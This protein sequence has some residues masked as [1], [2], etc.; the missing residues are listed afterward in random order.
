MIFKLLGAPMKEH[1]VVLRLLVLGVWYLFGLQTRERERERARNKRG[2]RAK[3]KGR[4]RGGIER[5]KKRGPAETLTEY[6]TRLES[7]RRGREAH[8]R[9]V[10]AQHEARE[11]RELR[12]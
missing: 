7:E 8:A 5:R 12:G 6:K 10:G 1:L 11:K 3:A 4:K 2:E 9:K